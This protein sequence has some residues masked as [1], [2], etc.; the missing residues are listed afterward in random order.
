MKRKLTKWLILSAVIM[1]LFPWLAVT[2]VKG[3]AG[4][5]IC[6]ILFFAVN[7]VYCAIAGVFAGRDLPRLWISPIAAA[8]LFI[9]GT[10]LNFEMGEPAFILYGG[11]YLVL[12]L[13][14]MFVSAQAKK[15]REKRTEK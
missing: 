2:F 13:A 12:G 7:P 6:F 14:A 1:L 3:D 4:M 5:G 8:A 11:F 15:K 9:A 10:W